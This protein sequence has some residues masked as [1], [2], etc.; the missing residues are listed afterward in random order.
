M[1]IVVLLIVLPLVIACVL[2]AV[3]SDKVRAPIV[4][5]AGVAIGALSVALAIG[6]HGGVIQELW[7]SPGTLGWG[8]IQVQAE[9]AATNMSM[10]MTVIGA[11][12]SLVI[13]I[14]GIKYKKILAV[15]L[16]AVQETAL[17][18]FEL[19]KGY[20]IEAAD[21]APK[22]YLYL[23]NF[24]LIMIVIIGVIGSG[25]CIYALGYMKDYQH[26]ADETGEKDRRPYFFFLNFLFL[27]AMI[28]IV[29]SN[30][31]IWMFFFW[32]ITTLCSFLLIG[33]SKTPEA[34]NNSF[35]AVIFNLIGGCAFVA[36]IIMMGFTAGN[37]ELSNLLDI[38]AQLQ[39]AGQ[40][41]H[42]LFGAIIGL[43]ALAGLTKA[44]QMPFQSW[45]LGAMVAPTPV[46][47]LLHSST[48]VKAGVFLIIK[49]APCLGLSSLFQIGPG[50]MVIIIGG[51]TFLFA[52]LSALSQSNAKRVLAYSTIAN[53]GL[54]VTC[55]GV[56]TPE[57]VW[58]AIMLVI[59]HAVTKALLF[60][61]VG[62]AEHRIGSRDI[63][64]MDGLF[65]RMPRMAL[66][67]IVGIAGMFLAP[68]GMLISKWAALQAFVDSGVLW[69]LLAV[70]FGSAVTLFFWTKWLGKMTAIVANRTSIETGLNRTELSITGLFTMFTIAVA[71]TFPFF[72][73]G[74]IVPYLGATF[75][76]APQKVFVALQSSDMIVMMC[77]VVVLLVLVLLFY[78]ANKKRVMPIYMAGVNEGD[79]L[80]YK[81][82]MQKDIPV[83][84]RNWY[85][86][87]MFPEKSMNRIGVIV[88][89]VV[90]ALVLSLFVFAFVTV[91]IQLMSGGGAA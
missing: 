3:K 89:C 62:T 32:E 49:L 11:V 59:F 25:I 6:S 86:E 71:V 73:S 24:S 41:D 65:G 5:G 16:A 20:A 39:A 69:A 36:A 47:A 19:S 64:D 82:S 10:I 75:S 31:L 50:F 88:A 13:I 21:T 42:P 87:D 4:I 17:L 85:F 18:W 66:F 33:F 51:A 12:I 67:M 81:G 90:L 7:K 61:C 84:L 63:E 52:S 60:L 9:N 79:D 22:H 83:T 1:S 58:C 37:F 27:A 30:N 76:A 28:G 43:L 46:S 72:S 44:A 26:H 80:T 78:G 54:I 40:A 55:A 53:L 29:V 8:G 91:G 57:A 56:G 34:I 15:V 74:F 35:R 23:D 48:M 68:F 70:I 45:L 77:L 14:L 2:L 38:G